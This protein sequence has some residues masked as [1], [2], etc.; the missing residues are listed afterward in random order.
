MRQVILDATPSKCMPPQQKLRAE[1]KIWP[2]RGWLIDD[3]ANCVGSFIEEGRGQYPNVAFSEMGGLKYTKFTFIAPT[4]SFNF[5]IR[6]SIC[7]LG[8]VK[9]KWGQNSR[10]SSGLFRPPPVKIRG[11]MCHGF[12]LNPWPNLWYS[13]LLMRGVCTG[14]I[15]NT[16]SRPVFHG[17]NNTLTLNSRS[18]GPI[19]IKFAE[20][21]DSQW[22]FLRGF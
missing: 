12:K 21:T 11:E 19:Y 17:E 16:F 10:S 7:K 1:V 5:Q 13:V 22:R 18:W 3:L 8:G 6:F 9:F 20:E 15:F 2:F 14:G 4:A